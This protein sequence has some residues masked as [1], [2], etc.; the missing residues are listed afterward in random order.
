MLQ[1]HRII[2]NL[3]EQKSGFTS[4]V[5]TASTFNGQSTEH[6]GKPGMKSFAVK[7]KQML[8]NQNKTSISAG[9]SISEPLKH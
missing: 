7:L 5:L 8:K 6:R 4:R 2:N 3:Q 9:R 1:Q